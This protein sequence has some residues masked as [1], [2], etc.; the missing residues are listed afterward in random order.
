LNSSMATS[1]VK[2]YLQNVLDFIWEVNMELTAHA[3]T[4][5]C[6]ISFTGPIRSP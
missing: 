3:F 1:D 6:L 4:K 5:P 2:F